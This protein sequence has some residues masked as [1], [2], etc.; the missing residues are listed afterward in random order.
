MSLVILA[1]AY[2]VAAGDNARTWHDLAGDA[3]PR[4]TDAQLAGPLGTGCTL[5]NLLRLVVGTWQT[6][7]PTTDP[8]NGSYASY[9]TADLL[10]FDLELKG[11]VNP[12]G[13]ASVTSYD[14]FAFGPS[15]LFGAIEFD[16]DGDRDTG[17]DATGVARTR[18]LA[19][20]ARF[21]RIPHG[22]IGTRV[23]KYG[24]EAEGDYTTEPF[25][26]R[27]GADFVLS[28]CGCY[29]TTILSESG[30][31]NGFFEPGETW[32]IR[33]GFFQRAG[34]YQLF[35]TGPGGGAAPATPGSYVPYTTLRWSH[36]LD[37]DT[38]VITLIFPATM[39]GAAMLAGEPVQLPDGFAGNH[40]SI[41]EGLDDILQS[42]PAP[43]NSLG[44]ILG[45]R[46]A[47][48][49][50][51]DSQY[52]D[53]ARWSVNA[54]VGTAYAV[55]VD[56]ATMVWTDTGFDDVSRDLDGDGMA[57][58]LDKQVIYNSLD[59]L[60]G[61][62]RDAEGMGAENG[63]VRLIDPGQNFALSDVN[64]DG[65]INRF[66]VAHLCPGDFNRDGMI[67][68]LDYISF[69]NAFN[70]GDPRADLNLN[71]SLETGDFVTFL[72]AIASG[73]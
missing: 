47:G 63:N 72:N 22:S 30:S 25:F 46:W 26:E 13:S 66:D 60:D 28:F 18:Y 48:R 31:V 34:G 16:I 1:T 10:R 5:P 52:R 43:F 53:V 21:G 7:T 14:P 37:S 17:G 27:S 62:P 41:V 67:N 61:T 50:P 55:P 29:A 64:G 6:P 56:D 20:V 59:S 19:N 65:N 4:R 51:A 32:L 49:D 33:G 23:P 70:T 57:G 36:D 15:P 71:G 39:A 8:Y 58:P 3:I 68:I 2:P 12:P 40:V 44:W 38:T 35:C 45:H 11:V 9:Q 69:F 73:C 42:L 54:L 24:W